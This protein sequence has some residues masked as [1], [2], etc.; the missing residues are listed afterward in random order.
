MFRVARFMLVNFLYNTQMIVGAAMI[1]SAIASPIMP[2]V[3]ILGWIIVSI[4]YIP[5]Y[6]YS[7]GITGN[8]ALPVSSF[9]WLGDVVASYFSLK[10]IRESEKPFPFDNGEKYI[11]CYTPHGILPISCAWAT[12]TT[13]WNN[14]FPNIR[15]AY[16]T[17]SVTHVLPLM[18]DIGHYLGSF[19][20]T[21]Q[22]FVSALRKF[23]CAL[24]VPGGQAEMIESKSELIDVVIN[25]HH[26]GFIR[27]ALTQ[28]AHLVPCFAFG[29]TKILVHARVPVSLVDMPCVN[30]SH[31][32]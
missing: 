22:G 32:F 26:R 12:S 17:A 3:C 6:F 2:N 20:V 5:T 24:M 9:R 25:S 11:L 21:T 4:F 30:I 23:R 29:E 16:L 15:P 28:G 8:R 27:M 31:P 14:L 13:L 1:I 7:P 18:R 19:E 10:I